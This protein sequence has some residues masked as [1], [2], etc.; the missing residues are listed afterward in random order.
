MGDQPQ[1]GG[2]GG[3]GGGQRGYKRSWKNYFL[4]L[5]Y[6]LRFTL[7][8]VLLCG[9]LMSVLGWWVNKESH[10]AVKVGVNT[11]RGNEFIQDPDKEIAT[12]KHQES[13]LLWVLAGMG[14]GLSAGLFVYGI[15]MTHKVAGP[16]YKIQLYLDKVK[17]GRFDKVYNLRKGDQLVAFFEHFKE[18]HEALRARQQADVATLKDVVSA[19]EA[20]SLGG[21]SPQL[22]TSLEEL[23]AL[24]RAKEASLG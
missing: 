22:G 15:R 9:I 5:R 18:A 14:V 21:K 1:G 6:Q 7:F 2:G 10:K 11:I 3:G 16:L 23:K 19:A 8:M 13:M 20:A 12:L 17:N 4:N 24:L